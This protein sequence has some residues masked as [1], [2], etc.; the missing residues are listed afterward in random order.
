MIRPARRDEALAVARVHVQADR[1]TYTPI[2]A[3]QFREVSLEESLARWETAL[4]AGHALLVATD[5]GAIVGF[6][7]A[8]DAWMSALYLLASH[9]RRGIGARLLTALCEDVRGRGVDEIGFTC[10]AAN[11]LALAFYEAMGA[12]QLGRTMIGE[13]DN[14]WEEI[15]L[16]LCTDRPAAFRRG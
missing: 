5:A 10:V 12:R 2:F 11:E 13:G 1:E 7:H 16:E 15:V 8:G 9:R 14:V 4:T 3:E 6:A